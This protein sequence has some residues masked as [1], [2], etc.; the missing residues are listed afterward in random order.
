MTHKII[1]TLLALYFCAGLYAQ[2][3]RTTI[4][5]NGQ[6]EFD[7]TTDAFPPKKFTRK[8]PVPG[9]V[10]L[11]TPRIEEY[12]KFFKKPERSSVTQ[13]LS[14]PERDYTPRYSWYRK[15][16]NVPADLK[17]KEAYITIK[18]SQYVTQIYVNG[19]DMGASMEC[20]T[21]VE[22]PI[23]EAIKPGQK[24]EILIK[25]GDRYW[26]P[27][28][29]P[30]SVDKE[31]VHYLPG[32][33]DD[34][35]LSF[36][37]TTRAHK[38]LM[39]PSVAKGKVTAKILLHSLHPAVQVLERAMWLNCRV[40]VAI[41]EKISGKKVAEGSISGK[42][43]RD[44]QTQLETDIPIKDIRK[45]SPDEPFLY[46]AV[47]NVYDEND[48]LSD[49]REVTFG[50]RDFGRQ[51][52]HF[53]L[54]GNKIYLRGT[55]ITLQRFFEDPDCGALAWDR[56]WVTRLMAELPKSVNWNAM[57]I[58][59][60]VVPDFWYDIADEAGIML[61]NEWFY[62]HSHGWDDQTRTEFYNWVWS[63]GNHP[64]IVIWDAINENWDRYIGHEL[65]PELKKLDPTRIWDTGYMTADDMPND[66]MDE[67]HPYRW[68]N[69]NVTADKMDDFF[70]KNAY[71]LGNLNDWGNHIK[72]LDMSSPQLVNEYGWIWLWRDGTTALLTD[73]NYNFTVGPN[74]TTEQ[75]RELQAYWLQ[76]E[77][78]WLR[79]ER[80]L[81]GVLHFCHLTNNYGFTGDS[82]IGDIKDLT[83]SLMFRWFKHCFSP[84][85]VFINL[86][87]ERYTKHTTP[88]APGSQ[89][90]FNLFGI[91]DNSFAVTGETTV[92]LYNNQGKIVHTQ[93]IP[94]SI[95]KYRKSE[96]PCLITLPTQSGGYLM[97]AEYLQK[98]ANEPI[99]SRRYV[100]VG[101]GNTVYKYH[102]IKP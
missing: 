91:N 101:D 76:L 59:V 50:M 35:E 56:Q 14:F 82:F 95:D 36:T 1:F 48:Q 66:E 97:T 86:T 80:S 73:N 69:H 90:V 41:H 2:S 84:S 17:G 30:G 70:A 58:C 60:G 100:K 6:W 99:I 24:N 89:L 22:F 31:K 88:H 62:W 63:D 18:K 29:A 25:V 52:K 46:K 74:A 55:N 64:S 9:L 38:I 49:T 7:Q 15:V 57:R 39:L 98:G 12:D 40:E 67:P 81:A 79:A 5:L 4:S 8:I 45:W 37:G 94:T 93:V 102:E 85:A 51:G 11:A 83:P 65:I 16:I 75:R 13:R 43:K 96:M 61:Q 23:T 32:I 27:R 19:M 10:H 92:K 71:H 34:V 77:T 47:V 26:L 42:I 68:M 33:W 44:N 72:V 78:E 28:Q 54:N 21:P 20:Y 3:G 87:D 53:T